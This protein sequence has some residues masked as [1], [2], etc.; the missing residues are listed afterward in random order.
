MR[1]NVFLL[2]FFISA[3]VNAQ[4]NPLIILCMTAGKV[5]AKE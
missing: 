3:F 2:I 5:L 1:K 4:K